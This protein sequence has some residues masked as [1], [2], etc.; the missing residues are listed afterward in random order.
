MSWLFK[1]NTNETGDGPPKWV[2]VS[3]IKDYSIAWFFVVVF[4][5]V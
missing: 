4:F 1:K 2:D 3:G 5:P